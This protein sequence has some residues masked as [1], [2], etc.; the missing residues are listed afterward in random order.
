MKF[1]QYVPALPLLLF[2]T[3]FSLAADENGYTARYECRAGNP[4]CNVDVNELASRNCD[5]IITPSAPWSSINWSNNT[6]CIAPGDHTAKGTLVP[7]SS[8]TNGSPK[9]LRYYRSSDN[10]DDPWNQ[11]GANQ[12]RITKLD[13]NGKS[14]WIVHRL[15]FVGSGNDSQ[16]YLRDSFNTI[17]NRVL[18]TGTGW[19]NYFADNGADTNTLQNSVLRNN[20]R[21]RG[22]D[23]MAIVIC[24]ASNTR[25]VN[26]EVYDTGSHHL[27][28]SE[29]GGGTPGTIIEN[30]D[31]YFT[32]AV[33]TDCNGNFTPSGPC[34]AGEAILSFKDSGSSGN[35][36]RVIH[37]RLW[38]ARVNDMNAC[39]T[40]ASGAVI[41]PV[42]GGYTDSRWILFL[43]NVISDAQNAFEWTTWQGGSVYQHSIV[44]NLIHDIRA[45]RSGTTSA[46]FWWG[47]AGSVNNTEFYLNTVINSNAVA[48]MDKSSNM[49]WRCNVFMGSG[50]INGTVGS[51]S[52]IDYNAY[53]ATPVPSTTSA[54]T[55]SYGNVTDA[56]SISYNYWRKLKTNPEQVTVANARATASSPHRHRCDA[57]LGSRIGLGIDD[58]PP[59][60]Q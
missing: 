51:G 42:G 1:H 23:V 9:V 26:N 55:L 5:Q 37:N 52:T 35:P 50:G 45:F 58:A 56:N 47:G 25:V 28:I 33:Y 44:G 6:I 3:N 41:S 24:N 7:L 27:Q 38:G 29:C 59:T 48:A 36:I 60:G 39:C 20:A 30:N 11:S 17:V 31:M 16:I 22:M 15:T 2:G 49:D 32:P 53:Y 12:A 18:A 43:N 21:A 4:S 34:S 40:G 46:A 8:G 13:L 14:D 57:Q 19:S 10:N 54:G